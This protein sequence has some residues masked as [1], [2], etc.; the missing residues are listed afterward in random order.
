MGIALAQG[1][2][3][4]VAGGLFG[5]ILGAPVGHPARSRRRPAGPA[6]VAALLAAGTAASAFGAMGVAVIWHW[7]WVPRTTSSNATAR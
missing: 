6:S 7:P 3:G 2:Q 5:V 1:L 4:A